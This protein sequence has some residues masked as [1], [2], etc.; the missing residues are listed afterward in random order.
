MPG[1]FSDYV[2]TMERPESGE[3]EEVSST[4]APLRSVNH[5]LVPAKVKQSLGGV[6][7]ILIGGV[8]GRVCCVRRE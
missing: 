1:I 3:A 8:E 6:G 4:S 5:L 7:A 2:V